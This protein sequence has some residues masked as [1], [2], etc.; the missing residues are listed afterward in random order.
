M[1]C[2]MMSRKKESQPRGRVQ[3]WRCR[4]CGA[5]WPAEEWEACPQCGSIKVFSFDLDS[6]WQ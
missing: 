2:F 1:V 3:M 6:L 5:Q 4:D